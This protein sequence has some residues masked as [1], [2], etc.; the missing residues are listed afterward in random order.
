M[1]IS[2]I[3]IDNSVLDVKDTT[4]RSTLQLLGTASVKDAPASGN[5]SNSQVVLGNDTRLSD[6]RPAS[7][8]YEWAKASTKPTYTKSEVGL[9]NVTNDS[10]VKRSEMGVASGVAT[11]DNTGKVPSTQLPSYVDDVI[12]GYMYNGKFYAESTHET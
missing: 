2:K 3:K 12:E 10:Q 7:D 5:A 9:G 1:D 6:P 4:A 11:L 8:V